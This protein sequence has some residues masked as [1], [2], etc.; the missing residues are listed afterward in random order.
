MI[1]MEK[2][3]KAG[4]RSSGTIFITWLMF[5]VCLTPESYNYPQNEVHYNA[6]FTLFFSAIAQLILHL[7]SDPLTIFRKRDNCPESTAS[8]LNKT[9]FYW[10]NPLI[11]RGRDND[12]D[13]N[14]LYELDEDMHPDVLNEKWKA[15]WSKAL[16]DFQI[17][18]RAFQKKKEDSA[19]EPLL[20]GKYRK[21]YR[22]S[23]DQEV[24]ERIPTMSDVKLPSIIWTLWP[25]F[26]WQLLGTAIL[27]LFSDLLQ[28]ASPLLLYYLMIFAESE[29]NSMIIGVMYSVLIFIASEL[30]S[31]FFN[32]YMYSNIRMSCCVQTILTSAIYTKTLRLSNIARRQRTNG[33]VMNLM[34]VD[35]DQFRTLIPQLQQ[36]WSSPMQIVICIFYLY[37]LLGISVIAGVGMMIVI[38]PINVHITRTSKQY[39]M[40]QK[41]LKEDRVRLTNEIINGIKVVKLSAWEKALEDVIDDIRTQEMHLIRKASIIKLIADMLNMASPLLVAFVSFAVFIKTNPDNSLK[42]SI[43]FVSMT[44]FSQLKNPFLVAS[45]L[46][47]Y[48]IQCLVSNKRIK[49]FLVAPELRRSD[50][51][52]Q[53]RADLFDKTIEADSASFVWEDNASTSL[54]NIN[55]EIERGQLIALVGTV[56]TGKSSI[57]SGLL[58]DMEKIRG[59]IGVRGMIAY[60]S[61][62]PWILNR[63]VR[64]NILMD[65]S[66]DKLI[67]D[68]V[69]EGCSLLTDFENLPNGDM[70]EI[71]EKGINLSAGQKA[72]IALARAVYQNRDVYLL[73]D[74]LS[75]VDANVA[76][77]IFKHVLGPNGLLCKKTRVIITHN[78]TFL[79]E[80]DKI[81]I[82][83]DGTITHF[84]TYSNLLKDRVADDILKRTVEKQEGDRMRGPEFRKPYRLAQMEKPFISHPHQAL[85]MNRKEDLTKELAET[86]RVKLSVYMSYLQ[87][88]GLLK[89]CIP[90]IICITLSVGFAI[91]R[92]IWLA[93]WSHDSL[94][95]EKDIQ[96]MPVDLRLFGFLSFGV[97]EVLTIVLGMIL[98]VYGGARASLGLHEP[99]FHNLMRCPV[100]FFD[101]TPLSRI[102]NRLGK[103]MDVVDTWLA[104]EF[105]NLAIAF[106]N[107]IQVYIIISLSSPLFKLFIVPTL[108]VYL[109]V[110]RY[111][112]S[113]SRQLQRLSSVSRSP[114]YSHFGETIQGVSTIRAFGWT[115]WFINQNKEKVYAFTKCSYFSMLSTCW[116]GVRL[117]VLGNLLIFVTCLLC[118]WA[119]F[120]D[121]LSSGTIGLSISYSLNITF[122]MKLFIQF[123]SQIESNS[124]CVER[125]QEYTENTPNEAP[126]DSDPKPAT[127]WPYRGKITFRQY[128]AKY[129]SD[130]D[131]VLKNLN[132]T[133]NAGEKL[134]VVG[135]SGSGKSSLASAL[136]RIFEAAEGQIIIDE[137]DI[138]R[139]GLHDLR[140]RLTIIPQ[141]PVF[142]SGTVRFNLDPSGMCEDECLWAA[143]EQ[144][145]LR[146]F[147]EKL[148]DGLDHHLD[149]NGANLSVGQRQLIC[150]ARALIHKKRIIIMDEPTAPIDYNT[151][152]VIQQTIRHSFDFATV[153]TIAHRLNTV[154]DCD[155][156]IVLEKGTIAEV[157]TPMSLLSD[158]DSI[159]AE[160]AYAAGICF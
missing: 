3:R 115:K 14:D 138:G 25:I 149:E 118:V 112:V 92:G 123:L 27:K 17:R 100:S 114:I 51:D 42:P 9:L 16:R 35:V 133:I 58:G 144:S 155:R 86:G 34:A 62:Q 130:L 48:L 30:R 146:K 89:C 106:F 13:I 43:A 131:L 47:Q 129:R 36:F 11:K 147:V 24:H 157:G 105:Q 8:F 61:Q 136:F 103:D 60:A 150:L 156:I 12:L 57:L 21:R 10:M 55:L 46:I 154:L 142:F 109:I 81:A 143:L 63:T 33:Q 74:P 31:L 68:H 40:D 22:H 77:H 88:M 28:Y 113:T 69:V 80:C 76:N 152:H 29:N 37:K 151:D 125:I 53:M 96:V 2:V 72:R 93:N 1:T 52:R 64:E 141:D 67:Y 20:R 128:S 84:D 101:V 127:K 7:F 98:T 44:L 102:L 117:E 159:F 137:V 75:A 38:M 85:Q 41:R 79:R 148:E 160:L 5:C 54:Q 6:F 26:K 71:G 66:Y 95:H 111:F 121:S 39:T 83:I 90:F 97:M 124:V 18:Q 19:N 135:R 132:L 99:L 108:V 122:M 158:K 50:I 56:A 65:Q 23:A 45:N 82:V 49:E 78:L 116:L 91:A 87:A 139:I 110:L 73:D 15:Q 153:I 107:L 140:E 94:V 120:N 126:W 134:G 70:T 119:K 4:Y 145:H 59:Y 32:G 104:Q